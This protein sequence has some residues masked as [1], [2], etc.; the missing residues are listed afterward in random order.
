MT[1]R[2]RLVAAVAAA[3]VAT[4]TSAPAA[5]TLWLV[6]GQGV[7]VQSPT[8][9]GELR[10]EGVP[11]AGQMASFLFTVDTSV[12]GN[13]LPPPLGIGTWRAYPGAI[14]SFGMVIGGWSVGLSGTASRSLNVVDNVPDPA[15]TR[16]IDQLTWSEGAIFPGGVLTPSLTTDAPLAAQQFLGNFTFGRTASVLLPNEPAMIGGTAVPDLDAIWF[17]GAPGLFLSF[18][19]R[20]G[21]A[22]TAAQ[23]NALPRAR[24]ALSGLQVQTVRLVE[25][26][27]VPEP[28][29][30]AMLTTG[31]GLVGSALRRRAGALRA[32]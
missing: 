11:F 27:A 8:P 31:F 12:A 15:N 28:A 20:Q 26:P 9:P 14:G 7:V 17:T 6:G 4:G 3:L 24:F 1:A 2:S 25:P 23:S 21:T 5:A 30:W 32:A 13:D 29:T 10:L 22:S 19:V 16:R 18:D